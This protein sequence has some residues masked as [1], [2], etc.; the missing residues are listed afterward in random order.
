M[1]FGQTQQARIFGLL[2][3][4]ALCVPFIFGKQLSR[5]LPGSSQSDGE[6][7]AL[8]GLT[9]QLHAPH[10]LS[11]AALQQTDTPG[12]VISVVETL[13][14]TASYTQQ[15]VSYESEGNTIFALLTIPRGEKPDTG[16]PIIVFNHGYIPPDEYRT[17]E[18]YV[19]YVNAFA[20]SGYMVI[21]PDYR[22]HGESE[23]EAAGGYGSNAYTIDVLNAMASV[24]N[25]PDA[26]RE[27]VGMWGHSMG[28]FITLRAM[29]VNPEIR[30]GVIWGG[31]VASH[32]DLILNWRRSSGQ[33]STPPPGIATTARRWRDALQSEHGTPNENPEFW[34][35]LSA[36]FSL[37]NLNGRPIQLHHGTA[38]PTVPVEFSQKLYD[39]L[40]AAGQNGE[41]FTYAGDDHNISRSLGVALERSVTFFDE[42][43][44]QDT[45]EKTE[46]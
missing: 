10:P 41:I 3:I 9:A 12:S 4:M 8:S 14:P 31:V 37:Q 42:H 32:E 16:W 20:R 1:I 6:S 13:S 26:D 43:L 34:S 35:S 39:Q 24:Q 40:A 18:K 45:I 11:V 36:N 44:K 33:P 28:G 46:E 27:R 38:D 2:V 23:G 17:T 7:S 30:A 21:K 22:G 15:V 19:A 29:V 25:H 5:L